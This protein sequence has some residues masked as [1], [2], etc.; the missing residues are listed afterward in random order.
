MTSA[1]IDEVKSSFAKASVTPIRATAI[2]AREQTPSH[3]RISTPKE[4]Y[5]TASGIQIAEVWSP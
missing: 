3:S 1:Q 5:D 2:D 4:P